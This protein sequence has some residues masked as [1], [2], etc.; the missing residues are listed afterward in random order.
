LPKKKISKI[1]YIS[2]R[3]QPADNKKSLNLGNDEIWF[4]CDTHTQVDLKDA[5][6][7][8]P[9]T[10]FNKI[11]CPNAP[12]PS[13]NFFDSSSSSSCSEDETYS[14][15]NHDSDDDDD[16]DLGVKPLKNSSPSHE[17]LIE[18]KRKF[19]HKRQRRNQKEK[20]MMINDASKD[21]ISSCDSQFS[22]LHYLKTT[23]CVT[24]LRQ[25]NS[26]VSPTS[27]EKRDCTLLI[28]YRINKD[29][30]S[31]IQIALI[32]Y[33]SRSTNVKIR[34]NLVI[35]FQGQS[36]EPSTS[37]TPTQSHSNTTVK[38]RHKKSSLKRLGVS[39]APVGSK[40]TKGVKRPVTSRNCLRF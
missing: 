37:N 34:R 23:G 33:Q 7:T 24:I 30:P 35:E 3:N 17:R 22:D 19:N 40:L 5:M 21:I 36:I 12:G 32:V 9:R 25:S 28:S 29:N 11:E 31:D 38:D 10:S 16:D 15:H 2:S 13:R 39:T 1:L 8:P 18:R 14:H 20:R 27:H 6:K 26:D 4:D